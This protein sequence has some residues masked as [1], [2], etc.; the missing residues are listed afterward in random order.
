MG[1]VPTVT[2]WWGSRTDPERIELYTRWSF[3]SFLGAIPLF[4]VAVL[5]SAAEPVPDLA[6]GLFFAGSV[7]TAIGGVVVTRRGLA[8]HQ[9]GEP[10]SP[11]TVLAAF[12]AA[13]VMAAAGAWAFGTGESTPA[14]P[15]SVALPLG[16]I[17]TA[18]ATV[19]TTRQLLPHTMTVGVLSGFAAYLDGTS[20]P[21][22]V[23]Q[24]AV[25]TSAVLA[26]VLAFR[27][28]V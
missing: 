5:G 7:G 4:A 27:F 1:A 28:S 11:R 20:A 13:G 24:A 10:L 18:C 23:V 19:W 16:M 15:W 12:A 3:Y 2:R 22:A 17:L 26:V 21:G 8:A 25:L 6:V 9:R 14:V